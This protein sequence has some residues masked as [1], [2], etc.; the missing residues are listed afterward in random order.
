MK[1][2]ITS[3]AA[4]LLIGSIAQF[5]IAEPVPA[6][7]K[8]N[9]GWWADGTISE[10][11]F[12]QGIEFLIQD[13]IIVVPPTQVS[14]QKSQ[15]VPEWVKNNAAWWANGDIDDESFVQGIQFLIKS[16]LI[17]IGANEKS[18]EEPRSSDGKELGNLEAKL[19]ECNSIK[20]A[21]ERLECERAVK[22]E[23]KVLEFKNNSETYN[24]GS[25]IFYYPGAEVEIT[26]SGNAHLNIDMLVENTGN[27]NLQLMCS[28]PSVCNY[29]VW[30]G[31]KSFKY[32]STD[33]TSGLLVIKPG[34]SR[35]F[36]IF[37]GPNI[38]YG[39]TEFKYDSSKDYVFRINEPWGSAS[40]PLNLS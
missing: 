23:M 37:F 30:D 32:A 31:S 13:G 12:I 19:E 2:T 22:H 9:A 25:A 16:G 28:G 34:E 39:G 24:V 15:G 36:N 18:V 26:Q 33:F 38:G 21:Y 1:T 40:I 29:D 10:S 20:K 17:S 6:W 8:N 35:T 27:E 5:A 4:I 3:I 11:E 7:V 14:E